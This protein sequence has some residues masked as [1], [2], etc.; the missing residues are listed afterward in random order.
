VRGV[1]EVCST[2]RVFRGSFG[3]L[4]NWFKGAFKK[5]MRCRTGFLHLI[6]NSSKE[7]E[8]TRIAPYGFLKAPLRYWKESYKN[9][10][11][12]AQV[13]G[14]SFSIPQTASKVVEKTCVV[15][16]GFFLL[17]LKQFSRDTKKTLHISS[18]IF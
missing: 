3:A 16:H 2:V 18:S 9:L 6:W 4:A 10:S 12:I 14:R 1:K 7:V 17:P 8:K 15:P 5:P 13:F 11:G